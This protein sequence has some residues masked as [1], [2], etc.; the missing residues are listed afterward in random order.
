MIVQTLIGSGAEP[1]PLTP[2]EIG[3]RGLVVFVFALLTVRL[4]A[5]RFLSGAAPFDVI[6]GVMLG[7]ILSRIL[8]GPSPLIATMAC[9]ILLVVVH[10]LAGRL[11]LRYRRLGDFLLGRPV[12]LAQ[13]GDR[14]AEALKRNHMSDA[15][16]DR[17]PRSG[18]GVADRD[19]SFVTLQRSGHVSVVPRR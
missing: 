7:A 19:A 16:F 6:L 14:E 2:L 12:A 10:R 1:T 13:D 18:S 11:S 4:V 8:I 3:V 9:V 15:E 5:R 17:A